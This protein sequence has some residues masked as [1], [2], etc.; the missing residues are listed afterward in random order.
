MRDDAYTG[1]VGRLRLSAA[2]TMLTPRSEVYIWIALT[3]LAAVCA[4][5]TN[6]LVGK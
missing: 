6:S 5:Y 2:H 4:V 1:A 3:L